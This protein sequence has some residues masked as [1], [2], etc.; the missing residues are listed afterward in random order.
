MKNQTIWDKIDEDF[1]YYTVS[2]LQRYKKFLSS[3]VCAEWISGARSG[4]AVKMIGWY[5]DSIIIEF[6]CGGFC[7]CNP[8]MIEF[9]PNKLK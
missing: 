8:A 9:F 7:Y 5:G 6:K 2:T 4:A 3:G 1:P